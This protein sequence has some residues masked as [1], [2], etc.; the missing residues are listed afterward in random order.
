MA[1]PDAPRACGGLEVLEVVDRDPLLLAGSIRDQED[2]EL[3]ACTHADRQ[4]GKAS[5]LH[6]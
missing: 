6:E 1:R 4:M 5:W 3:T 2:F